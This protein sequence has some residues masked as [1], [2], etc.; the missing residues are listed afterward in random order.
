MPAGVGYELTETV[1][2]WTGLSATV[3]G[4]RARVVVY[5]L[6]GLGCGVGDDAGGHVAQFDVSGLGGAHHESEGAVGVESV[7]FHEDADRL[8]DHGAGPERFGERLGLAGPTQGDCGQ[9]REQDPD[10]ACLG[11]D[12]VRLAG[13]EVEAA[14]GVWFGPELERQLGP[15]AELVCRS[16][17]VGRPA[18]VGADVVDLDD[19]LVENGVE[20]GPFA[21]FVLQFSACTAR[22]SVGARVW[23]WPSLLVIEMLACSIPGTTS[24]APEVMASKASWISAGNRSDSATWA[25]TSTNS[26]SS[27]SGH[28]FRAPA[29]Y[30]AMRCLARSADDRAVSRRHPARSRA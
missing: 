22:T 27:T 6:F 28:P 8:P 17:P 24:I 15:D 11:G 19:R 25:I 12:G 18:Q 5:G 2:Q 26:G 4:T 1:V 20:A 21:Q 14:A 7:A 10:V 23:I 29:R 13:V 30:R 3:Q 16:W 9:V